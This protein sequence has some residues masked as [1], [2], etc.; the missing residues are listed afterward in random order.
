MF[1][2]IGKYLYKLVGA[3]RVNRLASWGFVSAMCFWGPGPI[4]AL[5]GV[6][7]LIATAAITQ[8]GII[9]Y[10]GDKIVKKL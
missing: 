8:S 9:G 1:K 5:V 4:I 2:Q 6:E 3:S 7:G 10:A